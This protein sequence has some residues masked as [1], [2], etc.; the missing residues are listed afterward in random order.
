MLALR[1]IHAFEIQVRE[2]T[3]FPWATQE[4]AT[5]TWKALEQFPGCYLTYPDPTASSSRPSSWFTNPRPRGSIRPL[6]RRPKPGGQQPDSQEAPTRPAPQSTATAQTP[7]RRGVPGG[8][9]VVANVWNERSGFPVPTWHQTPGKDDEGRCAF[10]VPN[11][12]Y[13]VLSL[14]HP[15]PYCPRPFCTL[16]AGDRHP[17]CTLFTGSLYLFMRPRGSQVSGVRKVICSS[18]CLSL[19]S[20]RV[21][22]TGQSFSIC[23]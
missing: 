19:V 11:N 9:A 23:Y 1:L 8:E 14:E 16:L 10:T 18:L 5:Q 15:V 3:S 4:R 12:P 22:G 21:I 7:P 20:S 6:S 2:R 17:P 13:R